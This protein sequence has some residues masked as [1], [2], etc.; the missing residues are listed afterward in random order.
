M[1]YKYVEIIAH[2]MDG[3]QILR[4]EYIDITEAPSP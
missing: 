1:G 2:S 3:T 4:Q